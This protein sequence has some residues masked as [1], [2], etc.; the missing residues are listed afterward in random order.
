M[1]LLRRNIELFLNP[2]PVLGATT[3]PAIESSFAGDG[4][5]KQP[6]PPNFKGVGGAGELSRLSHIRAMAAAYQELRGEADKVFDQITDDWLAATDQQEVILRRALDD[7]I[8]DLHERDREGLVTEER[9]VEELKMLWQTYFADID[10]LAEE[11]VQAE[12]DRL[13]EIAD[14]NREIAE[15][16]ERMFSGT[17]G[18]IRNQFQDMAFDVKDILRAMIGDI[19]AQLVNAGIGNLS[20]EGP[21][22]GGILGILGQIAG[23]AG[24]FA[25]GGTSINTG[26]VG[27][28][29]Y[30]AGGPV[31]AGQVAMVGEAGPELFIPRVPGTIVPHG[32]MAQQS[33]T[34]IQHINV[35][36]GVSPET[37]AFVYREA[38]RAKNAAVAEIHSRQSRTGMH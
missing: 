17:L 20:G 9:Y 15:E 16:I 5:G 35:S 32:G 7:Q 30:A 14:A 12:K 25:G 22:G 3:P 37:A 6:N 33:S 26:T 1:A 18:E 8:D 29:A 21:M 10:K 23:L 27:A 31:A 36:P 38:L 34:I 11:R 19:A 2:M 28:T 24:G 4:D 13:D